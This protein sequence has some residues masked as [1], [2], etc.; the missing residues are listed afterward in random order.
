VRP[1][2]ASSGSADARGCRAL[3]RDAAKRRLRLAGNYAMAPRSNSMRPSPQVG[4][5]MR[6]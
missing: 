4:S 5:R 3:A 6:A 2:P 1:S